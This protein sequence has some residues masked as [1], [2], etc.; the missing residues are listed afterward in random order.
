MELNRTQ[1]LRIDEWESGK[2]NSYSLRDIEPDELVMRAIT[3][4]GKEQLQTSQGCVMSFKEGL[5][6]YEVM[7]TVRGRNGTNEQALRLVH[8]MYGTHIKGVEYEGSEFDW[9]INS[10]DPITGDVVIN[11]HI[12]RYDTMAKLASDETELQKLKA[13]NE[14]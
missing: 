11:E 13:E 5:R 1:V 14:K 3:V 12:L 4:D 8:S 7:K 9:E 10:I 2:G 6:F